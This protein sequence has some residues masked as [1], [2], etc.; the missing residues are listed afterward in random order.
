MSDTDRALYLAEVITLKQLSYAL[1]AVATITLAYFVFWAPA[2]Q[3]AS[4]W[5]RGQFLV[6][7]QSSCRSCHQRDSSFRAPPLKHLLGKRRELADGSSVVINRAYL[8][9]AL[10]DPN[11]QIAK[12]YQGVMPSFATIFSEQQM[13]DILE[14]LQTL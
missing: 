1:T 14:Y 5:Q 8:K 6:E 11:K 13:E 9:T 4:P 7:K 3:P 10:L 2:D 12:G